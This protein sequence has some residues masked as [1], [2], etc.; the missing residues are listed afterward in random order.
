MHRRSLIIA[1]FAATAAARSA[2]AS[3]GPPADV[4]SVSGPRRGDCE[5]AARQTAVTLNYCRAAFHRIQTCPS[6]RV[7]IEERERILNN[8]NLN[9]VADEEV[10]KLYGAVLHEICAIKI[11]EKDKDVIVRRHRRVFR[12]AVVGAIAT[13][14]L[15]MAAGSYLNALRTGA[16]CWWDYR[17]MVWNRELDVWS[18]DKQRLK[19]INDKSTLFLDTFW[20]MARKRSIPDR[21]LVRSDDLDQL[22]KALREND[23]KVRLRVLKRMAPFLECYP[24]YWYYVG[25][26]Q[27]ALG[28]LFDAAETYRNLERLGGG[29]F[30]KDGLLAAA[31]ANRAA[32]EDYLRRKSAPQTAERA[33]EYANDSWEVNLMCAAVLNRHDRTRAAEDA[34]LRNLDVGLE[35]EKSLTALI[36]FY[37]ARGLST[38][39]RSRLRQSQTLQQVA[40]PTLL[41]CAAALGD[42]RSVQAVRRAVASSLTVSFDR[43]FGPDDLI[44]TA[45]GNWSL[46]E[47]TMKLSLGKTRLTRPQ[48]E[49]DARKF[50]ARFERSVNIGSVL[51]PVHLARPLRV[52]LRYRDG[53]KLA[54]HLQ[55]TTPA[56]RNG[57]P[58]VRP[59]RTGAGAGPRN[60]YRIV[61]VDLNK[62]RFSFIGDSAP[63]T[64]G[65]N[66]SAGKPQTQ[67]RESPAVDVRETPAAPVDRPGRRPAPKSPASRQ[68]AA[69]PPAGT[70]F[71]PPPP[72]RR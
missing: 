59:V 71:L 8:L 20:K 27:Q 31:T 45:A 6:K 51:R 53:T 7:L 22:D 18:I 14:S 1:L 68:P 62:Q 16:N 47:A 52:D 54:V 15:Q 40:V 65:A 38:K 56:P 30:R 23:P 28:Q 12:R 41:R 66:S 21:W 67:P 11:A 61:A 25:R 33:L 17:T 72:G 49:Y 24:P 69:S 39:L 50:T 58:A 57:P 55:P 35:T 5:Q 37:L 4:S 70:E 9:V 32:I 64:R 43:R 13:F 34:L 19:R 63:R 3:E 44:L 26:T 60:A 10:V 42:D 36:E 48:I 29:H 46:D 2:P